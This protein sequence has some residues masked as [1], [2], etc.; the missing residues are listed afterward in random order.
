MTDLLLRRKA[1]RHRQSGVVLVAVLWLVLLLSVIAVALARGTGREAQIVRN[2]LSR[3]QA[4]ALA[5][6]AV[7]RAVLGIIETD[8]GSQWRG[9]GRTY[10]WRFAGGMARISIRDVAGLVDLNQAPEAVL[11]GL[12]VALGSDP[13]QAAALADAIADF[14]DPNDLR[15]L[16][17]AE[18]RDYFAAGYPAGAKDAPFEMPEELRLVY[19]MT[20][21]LYRRSRPFVT[22]H[23]RSPV[24]DPASAPATVLLAVPGVTP[25]EVEAFLAR[26]EEIRD[27]EAFDLLL[28][29]SW[30]ELIEYLSTID[31]GIVFR[32]R[33][34]AR[35]KLGGRF[36]RVV[37]VEPGDRGEQPFSVLSWG[38][39]IR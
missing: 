15:R 28:E 17:G 33:V 35:G 1:G 20:P 32:V 21:V 25:G 5:D 16:N 38:Q 34:E 31:S 39:D 9:D 27:A 4:R 8:F 11:R 3:A 2:E 12:F 36:V 14:R 18:D 24:V 30:P 13:R 37:V 7:H 19:G 10:L 23:A 26:R 6:A 29:K 22:V